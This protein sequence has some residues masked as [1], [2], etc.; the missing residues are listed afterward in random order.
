MLP[1][2]IR[3]N[4]YTIDLEKGKQ[5]FYKPFYSLNLVELENPKNLY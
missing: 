3:I 1:E 2:H 5:P 4:T